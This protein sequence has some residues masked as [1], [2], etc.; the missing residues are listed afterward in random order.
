MVI[1]SHIFLWGVS[2]IKKI[3]HYCSDEIIGK[4]N[5]YNRSYIFDGIISVLFVIFDKKMEKCT[6]CLRNKE[7]DF[8]CVGVEKF[9][10]SWKKRKWAHESI[11]DILRWVI[12]LSVKIVPWQKLSPVWRAP[13]SSFSFLDKGKDILAPCCESQGYFFL[14]QYHHTFRS[15][16]RRCCKDLMLF[17]YFFRE[18]SIQIET[19][20]PFLIFLFFSFK[21]QSMIFEHKPI[22]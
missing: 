7:P 17:F 4:T 13:C 22:K 15:G 16:V 10:I 14:S 8:F 2:R 12:A 6:F 5:D 18:I 19:F 21:Y 20:Y 9:M 3:C 11:K 1:S